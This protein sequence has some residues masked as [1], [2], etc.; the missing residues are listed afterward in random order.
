[1]RALVSAGADVNSQD[2]D[3]SSSLTAASQKGHNDI[4]EML[5]DIGADTEIRDD[6]GS[7]ALWCAASFGLTAVLDAL[8][9][10]GADADAADYRFNYR[11]HFVK[12]P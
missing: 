6:A 2:N 12:Q 3:G 8:I 1:M 5:L 9:S 7:T 10:R 11:H 4:V